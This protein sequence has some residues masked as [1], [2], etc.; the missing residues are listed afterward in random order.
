M[1]T[2]FTSGSWSTV[3]YGLGG[4]VLRGSFCLF[5]A[6]LEHSHR[7]TSYYDSALMVQGRATT[8]HVAV[9]PPRAVDPPPALP[10]NCR[11]PLEHGGGRS[12][13]YFVRYYVDGGILVE[14]QWWPNGR[15]CRHA[16]APLASD[17]CR[18]FGERSAGDPILLFPH[19]ISQWD[20][21]LRVLGWDID[22]VAMTIS[23]PRA[24]LERL[25]DTLSKWPSDRKLASEKELRS[26]TG[27]LLHLC[28][29][30]CG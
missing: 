15:R 1:D 17:R 20:T 28:E 30:E 24:K 9:T 18:L 16:S 5:L 3:G 21:G 10:P 13:E 8:Q 27:R 11:V 14:A 6:A 29:V 4:V 26:L 2:V 25:R 12:T 19:R 22:T 23:V 7:H